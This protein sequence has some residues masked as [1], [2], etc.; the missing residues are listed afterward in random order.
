MLDPETGKILWHLEGSEKQPIGGPFFF[1][2]PTKFVSRSM[3]YDI[4]T[5]TSTPLIPEDDPRL[6]CLTGVPGHT[7]YAFFMTK[8]GLEL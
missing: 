1:I 8:G 6:E 3:I 5:K 2:S 4:S 7:G